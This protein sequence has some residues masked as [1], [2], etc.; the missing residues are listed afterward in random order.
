[1]RFLAAMT[2]LPELGTMMAR[3]IWSDLYRMQYSP[4]LGILSQMRDLESEGKKFFRIDA[5]ETPVCLLHGQPNCKGCSEVYFAVV[6]RQ[7]LRKVREKV[8]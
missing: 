5:Q 8:R 2:R 6:L 1:M 4:C 7:I 3:L